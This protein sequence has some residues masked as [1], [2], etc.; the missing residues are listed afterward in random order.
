MS[1]H[2]AA[3][4][5]R[6]FVSKGLKCASPHSLSASFGVRFPVVRIYTQ[7]DGWEE[8]DAVGLVLAP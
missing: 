5:H 1:S 3:R 8:I 4:T 2:L 6:F 7:K